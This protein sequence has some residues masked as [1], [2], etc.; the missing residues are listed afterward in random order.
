MNATTLPFTLLTISTVAS[1]QT[2]PAQFDVASIREIVDG[3]R[4]IGDFKSS[5]PRAEYHGFSLPML[6][7]EAWNVRPGQVALASRRG[8]QYG[9]PRDGRGTQRAHL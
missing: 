8:S 1:A 7:A 2:Q 9:I 6:I 3:V 4:A 5:G